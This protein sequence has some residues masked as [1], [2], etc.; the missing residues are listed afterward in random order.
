MIGAGHKQTSL[1]TFIAEDGYYLAPEWPTLRGHDEIRRYLE[2]AFEMPMDTI[3]GGPIRIEVAA[4]GDMTY[5]VGRTDVKYSPGSGDT[6][7]KAHY[8]VVWKKV[9]DQ[10]KAVATSVAGTR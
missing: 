9:N 4:S 1:L 7:M 3:I 8:L 5:E 2:A 6:T 10:W